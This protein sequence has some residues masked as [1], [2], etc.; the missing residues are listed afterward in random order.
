MSAGQKMSAAKKV[1]VLFVGEGS[2]F[3]FSDALDTILGSTG[4]NQRNSMYNFVNM[5]VDRN[6]VFLYMLLLK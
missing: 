2:A 3:E 5:K 4:K 1:F 6:K